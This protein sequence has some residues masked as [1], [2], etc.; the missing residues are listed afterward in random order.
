MEVPQQTISCDELR[1]E[2]QSCPKLSRIFGD[3]MENSAT[4]MS[5]LGLVK[6]SL[7]NKK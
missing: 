4:Y 5:F 3:A 6:D 7:E 1:A 2:V